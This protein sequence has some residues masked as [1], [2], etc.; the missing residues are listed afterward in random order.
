MSESAFIILNGEMVEESKARISPVNRGMMYGDGCFETFKSYQGRF[1]EFGLHF[2]RLSGGLAYLGIDNIFTRESLEGQVIRLLEKTSFS[3]TEAIIRIQCWREGSRGYQTSS[4]KMGWMIQAHELKQNPEPIKLK[5]ADTRCIPSQALDRQYKLSNGL[6]F[7]KA[8]QEATS[9]NYDDVLMLTVK[10]DISETTSANIF[11]L[12][13]STVFTP[14]VDCDLLPG[15][16][17][18]LIIECLRS[19]DISLEEEK[20]SLEHLRQAEAV[21]C[22]NSVHEIQHVK[23]LNENTFGTEHPLVKK[24]M[25]LFEEYK[26]QLLKA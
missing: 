26:L 13:G 4:Q 6:N 10:G 18:K 17:R 9:G 16:T 24:I 1:L 7:I 2:D 5:V 22:C 12:H 23:S 21:F 8:A 20:F 3:Q 25:I 11:W 14:S 19:N 15:I